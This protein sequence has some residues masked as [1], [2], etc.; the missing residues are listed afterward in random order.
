L[1]TMKRITLL[2]ADDHTVVRLGLKALLQFEKDLSVV[3]DAEDGETAVTLSRK[4]KPD[5][6]IMDLMMPGIDGVEAT[7]QIRASLPGTKVLILTSFGS[8]ASISDAVAAGASGAIVKHA[9]NEELIDA[10]R[11]V[12][13]GETVFSPEVDIVPAHDRKIPTLTQRQHDVLHSAAR[14]LKNAD[15]ALMLGISKDMVKA[16]LKVVFRKLGVANKA[17]AVAVA[18]RE[19]LL[20]T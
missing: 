13:D 19:N 2:L 8:S 5:I 14:G 9:S 20:K 10:I 1:T 7:R 3:G 17:E 4:L 11:I 6:V 16:H 12:A 18:L 15:I